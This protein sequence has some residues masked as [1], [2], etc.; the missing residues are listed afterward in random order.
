MD[1]SVYKLVH[2]LGVIMIFLSLGGQI[3]YAINGGAK[4]QNTWRKAAG[5]THGIGLLLVLV[6]GFGMLARLGIHWPWPGWVIG[7]I[8]IWV[9]LGATTAMVNR[10]PGSGRSMWYAVLILGLL[11][12]Y[13]A[14]MKPF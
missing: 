5:I 11:A 13:F 14:L 2:V 8:I 7:K 3:N 6:G 10:S 4:G 9:L 1:P 12:I